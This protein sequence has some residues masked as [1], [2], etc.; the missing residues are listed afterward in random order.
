VRLGDGQ[1]LRLQPTLL[2]AIGTLREEFPWFGEVL[3][4][5]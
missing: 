4:F 5:I 3:E 1:T 2:A